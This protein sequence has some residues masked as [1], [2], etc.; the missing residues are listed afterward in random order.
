MAERKFPPSIERD[1]PKLA[2]DMLAAMA[3]RWPPN[4]WIDGRVPMAAIAIVAVTYLERI[5]NPEGR[6]K[7]AKALA[8]SILKRSKTPARVVDVN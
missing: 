7:A 2:E 6:V 8:A 4:V 3:D 5:E 1:S